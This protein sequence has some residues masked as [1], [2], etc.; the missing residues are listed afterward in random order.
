[1]LPEAAGPFLIGRLAAT[2]LHSS[3]EGHVAAGFIALVSGT[4][5]WPPRADEAVE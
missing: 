1:V 5:A 2:I 4:A 3:A